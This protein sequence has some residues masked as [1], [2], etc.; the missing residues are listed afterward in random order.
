MKKI[1]AFIAFAL[2][3]SIGSADAQKIGYTTAL[4]ITKDM[5]EVKL[6]EANLESERKR[7]EQQ[8]QTEMASMQKQFDDVMKNQGNYS[9]VQLEQIEKDLIAKEKALQE[10]S[11]LLSVD[12]QKR[13]DATL[14]PIEVKVNAAIEAVAKEMGLDYVLDSSFGMMVHSDKM[15]DITE[16]VKARLQ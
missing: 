10:K 15:Y 6:A 14:K 13:V 7:A 3:L 12:F 5:P 11:R 9:P 4:E 2:F 1:L 8:I 16:K